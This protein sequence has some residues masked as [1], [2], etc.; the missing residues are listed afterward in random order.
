MHVL[1]PLGAS[2][3]YVFGR[4]AHYGN[5]RCFGYYGKGGAEAKGYVIYGFWSRLIKNIS[6][7]LQKFEKVGRITL[8]SI[9]SLF[10]ILNFW[11]HQKVFLSSTIYFLISMNFGTP[12]KLHNS[13]IVPCWVV[14]FCYFG[15]VLPT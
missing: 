12:V 10:G 15:S 11:S 3:Y 1:V 7:K 14:G 6:K 9:R 5:L 13:R 2:T 4:W 8:F